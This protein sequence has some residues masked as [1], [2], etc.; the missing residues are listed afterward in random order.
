[1]PSTHTAL[2]Y[3]LIFATKNRAPLLAAE[4]RPR[5]HEYLGGTVQGLGAVTHGV[6]GVAD[7]VHLLILLKPTHRLADFVR[8]LKK[9]S[10]SWIRETFQLPNFHWQE[11][12]GAFTVSASNKTAVQDYIAHQD[13]HHQKKSFRDELILL[14]RKSGVEYDERYLD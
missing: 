13:E 8:E 11:G 10:S 5:L 2:H 3:H 7:H 14:L 9:A 1:M 6:G 4:W 12:Y